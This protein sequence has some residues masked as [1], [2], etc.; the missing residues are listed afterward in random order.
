MN[1]LSFLVLPMSQQCPERLDD[2]SVASYSIS[3]LLLL[4]LQYA[5]LPTKSDSSLKNTQY[6]KALTYLN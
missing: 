6:P 4:Y 1:I 2:I 5:F 3:E